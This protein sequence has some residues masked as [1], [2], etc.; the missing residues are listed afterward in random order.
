MRPSPRPL[1]NVGLVVV[2]LCVVVIGG[3]WFTRD[4]GAQNPAAV[5]GHGDDLRHGSG[6][7]NTPSTA[8]LPPARSPA[9]MDLGQFTL[10]R[11]D[12]GDC[13]PGFECDRFVVRCPGIGTDGQGVIA[14]SAPAGAALGVV[15]LFSGGGGQT[16]WSET[17]RSSSAS[18]FLDDLRAEGMAVFQVRWRGGWLGAPPGERLGPALL[19]CRPATVVRWIHDERSPDVSSAAP[20]TCGFCISGHSGGASQAAYALSHYG[21]ASIIDALVPTGGPPHA[22]LVKGCTPGGDPGYRFT[23]AG[24]GTIDAS[25]GYQEAGPCARGDATF[26]DRWQQDS[27]DTGGSD[28]QYS[29]TRVVIL[30]GA[31][32][33]GDVRTHADDYATR[34]QEAGSRMVSLMLVPDVGHSF[35]D[36]PVGLALLRQALLEEP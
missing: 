14:S 19:A 13:P 9:A 29:H 30:V 8:L 17:G 23:P 12:D 18:H 28:Y 34:L 31:R 24:A 27:V 32:D 6:P 4:P 26:A 1:L 10:E 3:A 21:L 22:A 15:V 36:S 2:V 25:Y 35:F 11:A 5:D 20:G 7:T 33:S 16:W